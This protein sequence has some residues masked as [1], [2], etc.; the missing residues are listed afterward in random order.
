VKARAA[1]GWEVGESFEKEKVRTQNEAGGCMFPFGVCFIIESLVCFLV[2]AVVATVSCDAWA[3]EYWRP[4]GFAG[5]ICMCWGSK[6]MAFPR[7]NV[8]E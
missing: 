5:F 6:K 1:R 3:F 8:P 7:P 4:V 2:G